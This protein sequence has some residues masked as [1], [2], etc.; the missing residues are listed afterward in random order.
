LEGA[1]PH[2][3]YLALFVGTLLEGETI[4]FL[5][6]L[7]AY[8]GYL[9]FA[10][11]VAVAVAGGFLGDQFFF[12]LG[13]RY[14]NRVFTRFPGLATRAPRFQ[15]LL[16]RWDVHAILVVRFLYGL[17]MA[18]LIVIGSCGI[19]PWR[20]ALFDFIGAVLWAFAVAGLG[21]FAGQ[22]VQE[23]AGRLGA[24]A[25]L[26]LLALALIAGTVWNVVRSLRR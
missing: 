4:V 10:A 20:V 13:R 21:Y 12:F 16:R 18:A 19:S 3:G 15:A 8:H 5:A 17:R 9:S 1:A 25:V 24:S 22:A 11:V 6:G 14:G 2:L 23:L 7:A 26:L